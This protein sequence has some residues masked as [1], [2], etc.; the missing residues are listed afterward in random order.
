MMQSISE[1]IKSGDVNSVRQMLDVNPSLLS[2]P[3]DEAPSPLLLAIYHGQAGVADV[4]RSYRQALTLHEAAAVGD[5]HEIDRNLALNPLQINDFS[6]DG[7]TPLG[8][9]AFFGHMEAVRKLLDLGASAAIP[10]NN[11]LRVLPVHSALAGEHKEMARELLE[12]G[13]GWN[14]ASGAGWTPL[15]YAAHYGDIETAR[16]LLEHDG[17]TSIANADGKTPTQLAAEKGHTDLA[18]IL[19]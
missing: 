13:D 17:D 5:L 14:E 19:E 16:F 15:H 12:R 18:R 7:F 6:S 1:A 8:Y 2:M 9:A 4:L 10:S 11:P 3:V